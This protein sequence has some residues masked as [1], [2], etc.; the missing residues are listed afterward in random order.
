[1]PEWSSSDMLVIFAFVELLTTLRG[2]RDAMFFKDLRQRAHRSC[3]T[4]LQEA[5]ERLFANPKGRPVGYTSSHGQP[6]RTKC[7]LIHVLT[8]E[9]KEQPPP[10]KQKR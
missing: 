3:W 5:S 8:T 6:S 10:E 7:G 4:R 9:R 1:M 2:S